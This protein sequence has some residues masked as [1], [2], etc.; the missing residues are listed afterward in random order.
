MIDTHDH[1]G[2][3]FRRRTDGVVYR[4][5][6]C[7][8]LQGELAWKREDKELWVTKLGAHGWV[9]VNAEL[10]ILSVPWRIPLAQQGAI[11]PS[12]I[13]VSR[14]GDKSYVYELVYL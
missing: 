12:G 3:E 7:E 14:K 2:F 11:P 4:Y 13:W 8:P 9:G 5:H 6:P 10:E 1:K